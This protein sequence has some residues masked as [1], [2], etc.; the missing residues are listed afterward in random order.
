M[1]H[2]N[3][4]SSDRGFSGNFLSALKCIKSNDA[5]FTVDYNI[6]NNADPGVL[7]TQTFTALVDYDSGSLTA[8]TGGST[9]TVVPFSNI[10]SIS[11]SDSDTYDCIT[12]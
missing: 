7:L 10:L 11:S 8:Q 2:C 3:R 9:V 5:A 6:I 1:S 4:E 12:D